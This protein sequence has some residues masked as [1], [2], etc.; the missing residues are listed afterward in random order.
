MPPISRRFSLARTFGLLVCAVGAC[1]WPAPAR[2]QSHL[3]VITLAA[4]SRVVADGQA[5]TELVATVT[6]GLGHPRVGYTVTFD[7]DYYTDIP[8]QTA[9]TDSSGVARSTI[10][11]IDDGT[12][13]VYAVDG[14]DS[15]NYA[16]AQLTAEAPGSGA[17]AMLTTPAAVATAAACPQLTP[18]GS[19]NPVAA[20]HSLPTPYG[21]RALDPPMNPPGTLSAT[22]AAHPARITP[23]GWTADTLAVMNAAGDYRYWVGLQAWRSSGGRAGSWGWRPCA[24]TGF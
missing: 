18:V 21:S 14:S 8:N 10:A 15:T 16:I 17:G 24:S 1:A 13:N 3:T 4:P 5:T 23:G 12:Y 20:I 9:T 2:A 19:W 22:R 11:T 7:A 6:D